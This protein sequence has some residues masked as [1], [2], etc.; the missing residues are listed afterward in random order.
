[1][2]APPS[3]PVA[4]N[5]AEGAG[6]A[7]DGG[8]FLYATQGGGG[9]RFARYSLSANAWSEVAETAPGTLGVGGGLV[10]SGDSLFALRGNGFLD[11]Y[12]YS[13]VNTP[14]PN[15]LWLNNVALIAPVGAA[16]A[17]WISPLA[18]QPDWAYTATNL[19][20]VGST[21]WTP[22]ATNISFDNAKLIDPPHGA[23]RTDAGT[24]LSAG[25]YAPKSDVTVSPLF[26][27]TCAN[28]GL[29]FGQ[30][31]FANI[32]SAINS[33][34]LRV[35]VRPGIYR[36]TINLAAGVSVIG[37]G[38][39]LSIIEPLSAST[40]SAV[41]VEGAPTT[42]LARFALS[43]AGYTAEQGATSARLVRNLIRNATTGI[44]VDGNTTEL[45]A[46]NNT[47]VNNAIGFAATTC[48]N[49]NVRNT[50]FA[51][52][53]S[54]G[55]SYQ[56]CAASN[57]ERYNLFYQNG[58]DGFADVSVNGSTVSA[59]SG[60]GV[61]QKDPLFANAFG[62]DFRLQ[63][64]SPARKAGNPAD[65]T[66][67]G[68][69]GRVDMGYLEQGNATFYVST[70]YC[71]QCINDG[72]AWNTDAFTGVQA[73]L[74]SAADGIRG[75]AF[76]NLEALSQAGLRF[77]VAVGS[78]AFTESVNVP[79][80]VALVGIGADRTQLV[81][82]SNAPLITLQDGVNA[83][84]ANMALIGTGSGTGVRLTG[85]GNGAFVERSVVRGFDDGI[86]DDGDVSGVAE[87]NTLV[88]NVRGLRTTR[89]G[90]WLAVRNNIVSN[91][92]A[93]GLQQQAGVIYSDFNLLN[94]NAANYISVIAGRSDKIN[95]APQ[96]A[97]A[98]ANNYWLLANSPAIDA[99]SPD[100]FRPTAARAGFA[101]VPVGG[102]DRADLGAFEALAAPIALLFG[103]EG[104]S[105]AVGNSGVKSVELGLVGPVAPA[106]AFTDT[107]PSVWQNAALQ[108]PLNTST[109]WRGSV[110]PNAEGVYRLYSRASDSLD[111]IEDVPSDVF[112]GA[113]NADGTAPAVALSAPAAPLITQDAAVLLVGEVSAFEGVTT[114]Q[115][116]YFEAMS[117]GATTIVAAMWR[118]DVW[119]AGQPRQFRAFAKLAPGV[120][121]VSAVARDAAGNVGRSALG[122]VTVNAS[123]SHRAT[124][125]A[126]IANTWVNTTTVSVAGV[127]RFADNTGPQQ[128]VLLVNGANPITQSVAGATAN[129]PSLFNGGV[130]LPGAGTH[131]IT[132]RAVNGSGAGTD[133]TVQVQ[134]D[135]TPPTVS[136]AQATFIVNS[137]AA[138]NGTAA[139]GQSGLASVEVS[140]DGGYVW[141][142]AALAG[143]SW[144]IT[145]TLPQY[146]ERTDYPMRAR[147][148]DSAGNVSVTSFAL[149]LDNIAPRGLAPV[150]FNI[151][152]GAHLDS[153]QSLV[154]TWTQPIDSL[155][156]AR[157]G[158]S[159]DQV[160]TTVPANNV[161]PTTLFGTPLNQ[162]GAWYAH[163]VA[164]DSAGNANTQHFGPWYVATGLLCS[165]PS[166]V[167]L[168]GVID[169]P[170]NEWRVVERL[171][172]DEASSGAQEL[173]ASWDA[174]A[175][176]LAW[177]GASLSANGSQWFYLDTQSGG[178][179][180]GVSGTLSAP[181]AADVAVEVLS[182]VQANLWTFNGTVWVS[183]GAFSFAHANG[184][185]EIRL[186]LSMNGVTN[187]KMIGALINNG[188]V[189]SVFPT[190]NRATLPVLG[191]AYAWANPCAISNPNAGQP[192]ADSVSV[193][194][195]SPQLT[196]SPL[197][198]NAS[199]NYVLQVKNNE[200]RAVVG[201]NAILVAT[202]GM[203]LSSGNVALGTLAA[204]S[205]QV[206]TL[207]GTL[208]AN[209]NG[210]D[211][212]TTTITTAFGNA[213]IV[214][215]VDGIPPTVTI[216]ALPGNVIGAGVQTIAGTA[217]DSP[218][219]SGVTK[220]EVSV[221][222][223]A[224]A[225]ANGTGV[226]NLPINVSGTSINFVARATD[227]A[228]NVS[229]LFTQN[230]LV[231]S[232]PPT[233]SFSLP[234]VISPAAS[235]IFGDASDAGT[236]GNVSDVE[237]QIGDENAAWQSVT[238]LYSPTVTGRAWA[239]S[240][241]LPFSDGVPTQVRARARDVVGNVSA[242]TAWQTT[243]VDSVAPRLTVQ[244][245]A[246]QA[247][248]TLNGVL[249]SGVVSDGAG[250]GQ[251]VVLLYAPDSSVVTQLISFT[252]TPTGTLWF[253]QPSAT[254]QQGRYAVRVVAQDTTGNE[255]VAGPFGLN[256]TANGVP[257]S[258]PIPTPTPTQLVPSPSPTGVVPTA[259][260]TA[261]PINTPT[262]TPT[263]T[264]TS[265]STSTPVPTATSTPGAGTCSNNLLQNPGFEVALVAGQNIRFWTELPFEGSVLQGTGYQAD[266]VNSAFI[267]PLTKLYQDV[268]ATAGRTYT[269]TFWAGTHNPNQSEVMALQFLN[270]SNAVIGQQVVNIDYD[271]D[272]D[273]TPPRITRYNMQMVAPAGSVKVRVIG[274]NSGN[275]I[276]KLDANC[277]MD[278]VTVVL[279]PTPTATKTVAPTPTQTKTPTV[280]PTKTVTPTPTQT[281]TA[282]P[283]ATPLVQVCTG[284]LL[285]NWSFELPLVAGQNI[286]FWTE[287]G[288]LT[289]GTGY[290]ADGVNSAFIGPSDRLYQDV[291]IVAGRAMSLTFW[292]GTHDPNQ[293][294]TVRLQ[295]LNAAGSVISQ[296][297]VNI[298]YDV[299]NDITPPRVTKYA[300]TAT[301]PAGTV[302]AR[303]MGRNDGNNIFK[304][305]AVCLK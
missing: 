268:A 8:D 176:Y 211:S 50:I 213:S 144:S 250:I 20:T 234:S 128:V 271:V 5:A 126:P 39:E 184:N 148:T 203:V 63:P 46:L 97:N 244:V 251:M 196:S 54:V 170:N 18:N 296:Q 35:R 61:L 47:V 254:L 204:R 224:F 24:S 220:V 12:R 137:V 138:I 247:Q 259:S 264:P 110:L 84:V 142:P 90:A 231:D 221:N 305:D 15:K 135:L 273:N 238:F 177:R 72:L 56:S 193:A 195:S 230:A 45:E 44:T 252:S 10:R 248:Q 19:Q 78:G 266:G 96:F 124:I 272:L 286:Q 279:P 107:V 227:R 200:A 212:V 194:L 236:V 178:S 209:L 100:V 156:I 34:A 180:T 116:I 261:E 88:N 246:A 277:L 67:L 173:F 267:G 229:A 52:N 270:A 132:A 85:A 255:S 232:T 249:F 92:S 58:A 69:A 68:L 109:Y 105:C 282:T 83:G 33:G 206:F 133:D 115:D 243:T 181:F 164:V 185:T 73:A 197:G 38:A 290:P 149:I 94:A 131:S 119:V 42:T 168:D 43:G 98:G 241:A 140:F 143:A 226:W 294:E 2:V 130:V 108:T 111:N 275:N 293:N 278:G 86:L 162:D 189:V 201:G 182:S 120:Y 101:S 125:I 57:L 122:G 28:D 4:F 127:A 21:A 242:P 202:T 62:N 280:T 233:V 22:G 93:A 199:V 299:D 112:E 304:L 284:N 303:V 91:N 103:K 265:T 26:C 276:F 48:A 269:Y 7:W 27:S 150:L 134:V 9:V 192:I 223:S 30:T 77:V 17:Q 151:P 87:F 274:Q 295:F 129:V 158:A 121:Q 75:L 25:Y 175:V 187:L 263:P 55:I 70:T 53:T 136:A 1:M 11:L 198:A 216:N 49:L 228:G 291:T 51:G 145:T 64:Q 179:S 37:S 222:G 302:K 157:V 14:S 285:Q 165:A 167:V 262:P 114:A 59:S 172:D 154:M 301:A 256:V 66:P 74:N 163:V 281:K 3:T 36:E 13:P 300:V 60:V 65:P 99:A 106:S 245:A 118:S 257:T 76:A 71:A 190:T 95:L 186:P 260:A 205:T 297:T 287:Q 218:D 40:R 210:I 289:Q 292:A 215:L 288:S 207:P 253:W 81:A 174:N 159:M 16:T 235:I 117:G 214:H 146:R 191:G 298:D 258:T 166:T 147:A 80:Y 217:S 155:S 104:V 89:A 171:D 153:V 152:P 23:Y 82:P 188:N 283:T 219:G 141:L 102:G 79:S 161:V 31:A 29:T 113:V 237:V 32:Q 123:V 225:I 139:D 239:F 183:G 208:G 160:S 240:W 6:L 41:Q 169:T